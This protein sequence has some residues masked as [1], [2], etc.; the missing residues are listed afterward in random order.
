LA[1]LRNH[2]NEKPLF[3]VETAIMSTC[4][5]SSALSAKRSRSVKDSQA[6]EVPASPT[7][8]V[9]S[10][11][12][13]LATTM[14]T[15]INEIREINENA[16]LLSLN[17][18]IEAARA[19]AS[20]AA[21]GVVA[22]ELQALSTKTAVVADDMAN[23]SK[24]SIEYLVDIIGGNVRGTRLADIALNNIDLIDRNLYERSCD[25]RWWA[26]D[27]SLVDALENPSAAT[28]EHA[29]RRMG[30]ILNA[31]TVY[32]DLVLCDTAGRVIANG[33]P[34]I[35]AS[36]GSDESRSPWFAKAIATRSGNEFAFQSA[37]ASSLVGNKSSLV[38]SATV[39]RS[40]EANEPV[41]GVLGVVFNWEALAGAVLSN[42]S[43][44]ETES[45]RTLR[46]IVDEDQNILASSGRIPVGFRIPE[47]CVE[48]LFGVSKG[49][50]MD[51]HDG[52]EV[53]IA[54]AKAPGFETYSTGWHSILIQ[55]VGV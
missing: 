21:F 5:S 25:V 35:Y 49:Y 44:D 45:Q 40:G 18:R 1:E 38:Y 29:C 12:K 28:A 53:C 7:D 6:K 26:T 39:R 24:Q 8:R 46:L 30:V 37:H 4:V 2:T 10:V 15:A 13:Q 36:V 50:L 16:K 54:H 55:E 41:I 3:L 51:K 23:K 47:A 48:K 17:A 42:A 43:L 33:R 31:Y 19:G 20:G 32:H 11:V 52:K 27:A 34:N 9:V 22:Q 14:Q